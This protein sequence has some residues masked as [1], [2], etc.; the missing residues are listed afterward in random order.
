MS[1]RS[2]EFRGLA[3]PI[4]IKAWGIFFTMDATDFSMASMYGDVLASETKETKED[5]EEQPPLREESIF[6]LAYLK[7][8]T[9]AIITHG[10]ESK[11]HEAGSTTIEEEDDRWTAGGSGDNGDADVWVAGEDT[12]ESFDN[13]VSAEREGNHGE[14]CHVPGTSE[15]AVDKLAAESYARFEP[16]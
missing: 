2:A 9:T 11:D 14:H 6:N 12:S 4:K 7:R 1:N 10:V 15:A 16:P 3:S 5:E 8:P 13:S